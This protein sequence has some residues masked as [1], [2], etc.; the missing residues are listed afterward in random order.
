MK[1]IQCSLILCVKHCKPCHWLSALNEIFL[2]STIAIGNFIHINLFHNIFDA[3]NAKFL[4]DFS[5]IFAND[6]RLTEGTEGKEILFETF[7]LT[8]QQF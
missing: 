1:Q 3:L 5:F 7:I 2:L 8:T 4:S 6:F